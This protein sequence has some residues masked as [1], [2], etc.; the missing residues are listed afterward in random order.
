MNLFAEQITTVDSNLAHYSEDQL[1][2]IGNVVI[3]NP[4]GLVKAQKAILTRD[5]KK[6]TDIEFPWIELNE[7]VSL[8]LPNETQVK[9]DHL[10]FNHLQKK[11]LFT[12]NPQVSYEDPMGVIFA[13]QSQ[14]DYS[15]SEGHY[16]VT[17][18]TLIG[19]VRFINHEENQFALAD[20]VVYLPQQQ[21][22]VMEGEKN[23]VLFYDKNQDMQISAQTIHAKRDVESKKDRVKGIGE[24]RCIFGPDELQRLKAHFR[25]IEHVRS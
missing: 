6:T 23:R 20:Q 16:E 3:E 12:G 11:G 2:L 17:K 14:I 18:V 22:L 24:V 15:E 9:C 7:E 13:N 4:M 25:K 10:I 19:N 5:I 1:I 21:L 8:T